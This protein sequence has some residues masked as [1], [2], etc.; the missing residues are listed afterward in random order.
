MEKRNAVTGVIQPS[1]LDTGF[2]FSP[3]QV[4]LSPYA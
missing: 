1:F 4:S 2:W 3:G